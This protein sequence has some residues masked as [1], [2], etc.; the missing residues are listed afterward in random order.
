M[1]TLITVPLLQI[2]GSFLVNPDGS[3]DEYNPSPLPV[4]NTAN[5]MIEEW[6]KPPE[7]QRLVKAYKQEPGTF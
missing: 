5:D 4:E 2:Q 3:P 6:D 7:Q 1:L